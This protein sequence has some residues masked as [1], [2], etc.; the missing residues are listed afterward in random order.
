LKDPWIALL[1]VICNVAAQI[2]MKYAGR[3]IQSQKYMLWLSP[4]LLIALALYGGSFILTVRIF[5]SNQLSIASPAM[6]GAT[7]LFI[8]LASYYLLGETISYQK[9]A[10]IGIIF[11]GIV[12]LARS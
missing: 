8:V 4:W 1:A 3:D 6:A 12:V 10:G 2:A 9:L 11:I 7:F 5:A